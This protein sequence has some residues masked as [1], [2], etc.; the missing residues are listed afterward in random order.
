MVGKRFTILSGPSCVGKGPLIA[1]LN[2]FHP[3]V[4]YT[5]VPVIKSKESRPSGPR[6]EEETIWDNSDY[7][8]PM[9]EILR[10][11]RDP[12]YLV[13]DCRGLPQAVDLSKVQESDA[14]L[15]FIE[16]YHSIGAKLR[17][18]RF[19]SDIEIASVFIAPISRIEIEDL[20]SAG[21][22]LSQ[23]LTCLMLHKQIFRARYQGKPVDATLFND[24][25]SR[26]ED[27]I[28][29]L[30]SAC[31]YSHV[32]VNSDG[33][34]NPNWHRMPNGAFITRPE[35]DAGRALTSLA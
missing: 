15:L 6:P 14:E 5:Q 16:I 28:S 21:V 1:A 26:S 30:R 18:N 29:E 12:Q 7:F 34:G 13:G 23:Y 20:R 33:E 2:R 8:R 35:G 32:I 24:A 25:R 27:T 11:S 10:A 3:D 9:D 4:T 22:D 31:K 19:L 17:E